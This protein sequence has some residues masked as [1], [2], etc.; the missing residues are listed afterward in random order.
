MV[1][2]GIGFL[3][4]AYLLYIFCLNKITQQEFKLFTRALSSNLGKMSKVLLH[5]F[6]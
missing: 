1:S 3:V 5:V 2:C 6:T 4:I